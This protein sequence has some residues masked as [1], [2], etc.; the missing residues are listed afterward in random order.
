MLLAA[1]SEALVLDP[2][3]TSKALAALIAHVRSG[4]LSPADTVV[5]LHT[6][7]APATL[8]TRSVTHLVSAAGWQNL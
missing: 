2:T 4:E 7:G 3:Y 8:T 6:G 5:F 1:R